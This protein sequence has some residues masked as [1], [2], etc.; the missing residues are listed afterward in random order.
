MKTLL[1]TTL[2][3]WAG[4][5][6]FATATYADE[7]QEDKLPVKITAEMIA[8]EQEAIAERIAIKEALIIEQH[9]ARHAA[10]KE[11]LRA[12]LEARGIYDVPREDPSEDIPVE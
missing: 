6:V 4:C 12:A 8:I 7:T 5:L 1:K 10:K 2:W 3:V 11:K 9:A